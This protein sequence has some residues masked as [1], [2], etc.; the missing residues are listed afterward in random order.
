MVTYEL[1]VADGVQELRDD[2]SSVGTNTRRGMVHG[3][4]L[5]G[6]LHRHP[7]H[8]LRVKVLSSACWLN[9]FV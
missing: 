5:F 9:L 8:R 7:H 2:R 3:R 4:W 6:T 1:L